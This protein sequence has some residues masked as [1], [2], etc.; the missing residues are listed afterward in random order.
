[1]GNSPSAQSPITS[2]PMSPNVIS[3]PR[4]LGS[5]NTSPNTPH[6]SHPSRISSTARSQ[7]DASSAPPP[8]TPTAELQ[9]PPVPP[10]DLRRASSAA[11]PAATPPRPHRRAASHSHASRSQRDMPLVVSPV[12][13]R[14]PGD[15]VGGF[16]TPQSHRLPPGSHFTRTNSTAARP[17]DATATR[18]NS[19]TQAM[20]QASATR[21]TSQT[22]VQPTSS[23]Q[24]A[25]MPTRRKSKENPLDLLRKFDTVIIVDDSSSMEGALWHE[26][27]DALAGIAEAAA[28]YDAN[29]ID[30]HFLND[31]KVGTNLKVRD[32]MFD[33]WLVI[34]SQFPFSL[35]VH[36]MCGVFSI[37]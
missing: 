35:R 6:R 11:I 1:M 29:G 7:G 37:V 12:D 22:P 17:Q 27:R 18:T 16:V 36:T 4:S 8:Y 30:L 24:N 31:Q 25:R 23:Q 3:Q 14:A 32:L 5:S 2:P 10:H 34:V 20:L 19:S 15:G 26:S 13:D 21:T 28:Q 33:C 9:P